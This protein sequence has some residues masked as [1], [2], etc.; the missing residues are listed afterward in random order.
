M[1]IAPTA[2]TSGN[3]AGSQVSSQ[4]ITI[5]AG[6]LGGD[7][8]LVWSICVPISAVTA[9]ITASST[10]TTPV[11]VPGGSISGTE[12]LPATVTGTLFAFT[13]AGTLGGAS[14]D[15]G[16]VITLNYSTTGFGAQVLE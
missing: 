4:T 16:K 6:I 8:V 5:P 7:V 12:P 1:A 9:T 3:S 14:S 13:A 15:V 2:G 10:G 11:A